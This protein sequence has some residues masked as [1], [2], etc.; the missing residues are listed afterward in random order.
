MDNENAL[1]AAR[2]IDRK[3]EVRF[4]ALETRL[5]NQYATTEQLIKRVNELERRVSSLEK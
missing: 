1:R 3:L 5:D 4:K 2:E